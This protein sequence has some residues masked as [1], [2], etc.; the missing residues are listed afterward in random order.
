MRARKFDVKRWVGTPSGVIETAKPNTA[1]VMHSISGIRV[2]LCILLFRMQ[3]CVKTQRCIQ[4]PHAQWRPEH[5]QTRV[6]CGWD[7]LVYHK[8][9]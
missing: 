7:Q 1:C 4:E 2:N 6:R 9:N 8:V 5:R 3:G